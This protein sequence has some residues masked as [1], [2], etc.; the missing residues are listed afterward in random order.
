MFVGFLP[1]E[2][3]MISVSDE[4]LMLVLNNQMLFQTQAVTPTATNH[5][6]NG[7]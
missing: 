5:I 1:V 2:Q 4:I 6:Q 3:A 7:K